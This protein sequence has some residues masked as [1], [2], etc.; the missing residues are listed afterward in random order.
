M[1]GSNGHLDSWVGVDG[2][3]CIG[4]CGCGKKRDRGKF[5]VS[6]LEARVEV[7][8]GR[9]HKTPRKNHKFRNNVILREMCINHII[10]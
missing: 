1:G 6:S 9:V 4:G 3:I 10:L 2:L 8:S 5:V 7:F